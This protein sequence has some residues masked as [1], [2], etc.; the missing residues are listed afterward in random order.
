[1]N[2]DGPGV[3]ND[4]T[5]WKT[6][7]F[8]FLSWNFFAT[9]HHAFLLLTHPVRVFI[10][11]C[12]ASTYIPSRALSLLSR[13]R[14]PKAPTKS[15]YKARS[16][17]PVSRQPYDPWEKL[18]RPAWTNKKI[19]IENKN[20]SAVARICWPRLTAKTY[21]VFVLL[22]VLEY[23]FSGGSRMREFIYICT[24]YMEKHIPVHNLR[25]QSL[26]AIVHMYHSCA[27][28]NLRKIV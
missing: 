20:S 5:D 12:R 27:W 28:D 19:K 23:I 1:M 25:G 22:D 7:A 3:I 24:R 11:I 16:I 2:F 21:P 8:F 6:F 18:K 4:S 13:Y 10:C 26:C 15:R 9:L 17:R 14:W